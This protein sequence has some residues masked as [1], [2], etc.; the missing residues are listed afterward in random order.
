MKLEIFKNDNFGSLNVLILDNEFYFNLNEVGETLGLSNPRM[1]IDVTDTDYVRKFDNSTVSETYNRKLHNTG[2]LFLTEAGLYR[3]LNRSNKP[4]AE[5]FQKWVNKEVLPSIRKTGSYSLQHNT[6]QTFAEALKLAYEQQLVIEEQKQ[7]LIEAEP[8]VEF[9]DTVTGSDTTI[10]LGQAAKV[11]NYKGLGRNKLFQYLRDKDILMSGNTPYQKY[12]DAGYFRL[13]ETTWNTPNND[14]M[15]YLK[16][17]VYQKG[18]DF[19]SKVIEKMDTV[20]ITTN[21]TLEEIRKEYNKLDLEIFNLAIEKGGSLTWEEY[22]NA[23]GNRLEELRIEWDRLS[24]EESIGDV[25]RKEV[26]EKSI[27]DFLKSAN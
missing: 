23:G 27:D 8:K 3:M 2:E 1:S 24:P 21:M 14:S 13:I 19:L 5:V 26:A 16:T 11:L 15:I 7:K 6:P 9:Y 12:V 22:L 17:V 20:K 10:D 4:E 25:N 18:L